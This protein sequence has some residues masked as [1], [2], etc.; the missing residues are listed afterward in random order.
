MLI[1]PALIAG[2][3]ATLLTPIAASMLGALGIGGDDPEEEFYTLGGTDL[4][5]RLDRCKSGAARLLGSV[6]REPQGVVLKWGLP[7]RPR[8]PS[9]SA[10]LDRW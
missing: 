2:P 4:W 10:H 8:L 5:R 7:C 3:G 6:G 1:S 9:C